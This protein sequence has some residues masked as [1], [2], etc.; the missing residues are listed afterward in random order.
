MRDWLHFPRE[1]VMRGCS[2]KSLERSNESGV[3]VGS[4]GRYS[5]VVVVV[6]KLE[7]ELQGVILRGALFAE[8]RFVVSD[9]LA[10]SVPA[11]AIAGLPGSFEGKDEWLHAELEE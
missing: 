8:V 10:V 6:L 11:V 5:D 7:C 3:A 4:V 9:I 1:V 2:L